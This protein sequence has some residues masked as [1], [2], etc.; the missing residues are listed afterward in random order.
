MVCLPTLE[1]GLRALGVQPADVAA[2]VLTH[3]HLDHAGA[4]G[5]FAA[6]GAQVFVHPLGARHLVDPARLIESSR[7]VH[8]PRFEAYYGEPLPIETQRVTVVPDG[9]LVQEEGFTLEAIETAGHAKHH[10]AWALHGD[11]GATRTIFAGDIAGIRIPGSRCVTIPTPPPDFDAAAWRASL[12]R[13]EA[14]VMQL[15][16]VAR[17][18]SSATDMPSTARGG[19]PP[20]LHLT[21]GGLVLEAAA[22]LARTHMEFERHL[23]ELLAIV[24]AQDPDAREAATQRAL[25]ALRTRARKDGATD[26]QVRAFLPRSFLEM[27]AAGVGLAVRPRPA[28]P[29]A[30]GPSES[31]GT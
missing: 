11:G 20:T 31:T 5:A 30:P 25:E 7:R 23:A 29:T 8:G 24:S 16:P 6:R 26:A 21:H 22:H 28:P 4:A 15:P 14:R 9:G 2:V 18:S 13:L 12:A 17:G 10:H 3:I 27:N 1:A 19:A